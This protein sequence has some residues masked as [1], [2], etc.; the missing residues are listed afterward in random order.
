MY[1]NECPYPLEYDKEEYMSADVLVIGGGIAVCMSAIA[2]RSGQKVVEICQVDILIPNSKRGNP[3]M[4]QVH[5]IEK[6]NL[7]KK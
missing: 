4:N 1:G 5:W 3:P 7:V 6:K 2:A